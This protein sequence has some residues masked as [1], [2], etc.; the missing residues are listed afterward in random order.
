MLCLNARAASLAEVSD[1]SV[2]MAS[3]N[4]HNSNVCS[5]AILENNV[6]VNYDN[7]VVT[8]LSNEAT[9]KRQ[10][11]AT[12]MDMDEGPTPRLDCEPMC[13]TEQGNSRDI[14]EA[15]GTPTLLQGQPLYRLKASRGQ[16]GT[17]GDPPR[18]KPRFKPE[19]TSPPF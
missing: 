19:S 15:S 9:K 3:R 18:L 14:I 11:P 16:L 1:K 13:H 2:G 7:D 6:D 12:Q 8:Q 4:T 5:R 17:P 10:L